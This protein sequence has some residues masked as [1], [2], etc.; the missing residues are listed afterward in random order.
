M[1]HFK[2][3]LISVMVFTMLICTAC[4]NSNG[5]N[6]KGVGR[7]VANIFTGNTSGN[8]PS[9]VTMTDQL[10]TDKKK[11]EYATVF[12]AGDEF[13]LCLDGEYVWRRIISDDGSLKG[14]MNDFDF[15]KIKADISWVTGGIAGFQNAPQIS[16]VKSISSISFS[17]CERDGIIAAYN[18]DEEYFSG[19]QVYRDG[20]DVYVI[21][22]ANYKEYRVYKNGY[23]MGKYV[24]SLETNGALGIVQY[25]DGA[26]YESIHNVAI[27]VFNF[28]GTYLGYSRYYDLSGWTPI[29]NKDFEN[30]LPNTT[31]K[32]G[33]LLYIKDADIEIVNGGEKNYKN[34]PLIKDFSQSEIVTYDVLSKVHWEE[35][36]DKTDYSIAGFASGKYM[37]IYYKGKYYVYID[38]YAVKDEEHFIGAFD[39]EAEVDAAMGRIVN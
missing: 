14:G 35:G 22:H 29:L 25:D 27:Y 32:N 7:T 9:T 15:A 38:S 6:I 11:N 36:M 30:A 21:I 5:N 20:E 2:S 16:K 34:T 18:P 3:I 4:S 37:I 33:E 23:F 1:K 12:R 26:D 8:T 10:Y 17:E 24:T 13:F 31:L 28:Y 39:T 19:P